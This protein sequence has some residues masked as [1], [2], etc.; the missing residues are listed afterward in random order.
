MRHLDAASIADHPLVLHPTV[1]AAG[2]LPVFL[3]PEDPLAKQAVFLRPI[4]P[5]IDCLRFLDFAKRP[6]PDVV[7]AGKPDFDGTVVIDPIVGTFAHAHE[8]LS[9]ARPRLC[10]SGVVGG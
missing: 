3:G 5:I 1:L 9:S 7:R 8:T 10:R 4:C 6:A 2:A